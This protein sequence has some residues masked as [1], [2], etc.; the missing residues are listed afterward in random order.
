MRI[1]WTLVALTLLAPAVPGSTE[2]AAT[3]PGTKRLTDRDDRT[4]T[5]PDRGAGA[6]VGHG[7][8]GGRGR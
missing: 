7:R 4:G 8:G 1:P 6:G 5:R 2:D 3:N